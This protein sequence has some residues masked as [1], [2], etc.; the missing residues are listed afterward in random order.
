[1]PRVLVKPPGHSRLRAL[2][3]SVAWIEFFIKHGPGPVQGMQVELNDEYAGFVVDCYALDENGRR[4]IDH[5]FLSRP[6][7]T[8]KSGLAS[9]IALFEGLGPCR[10]AGFAQGGETYED[11]WGLG[12]S[13]EYEPGEPMGKPVHVP[14]IRIMATEAEQSSNVYET[15]QFNLTDDECLLSRVPGIDPGRTRVYLPNGGSII[16]STASSASKDGGKETFIVFDAGPPAARRWGARSSTTITRRN[17]PVQFARA[18]GNVRDPD[19][20]PRQAARFSI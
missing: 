8:N 18:S 17:S 1:M 13:Y 2:A 16:P 6:K 11:P 4:L 15:I 20:Q 3:I 19:A 7:G 12:F 9:Y 10:F 5:S 14:K